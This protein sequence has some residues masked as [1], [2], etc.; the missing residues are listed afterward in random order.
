MKRLSLLLLVTFYTI[1]FAQIP[2]RLAYQGV[3]TDTLGN[4]KPDGI[5]TFT[6]RLY[7]TETGSTAEWTEIKDIEVNQGLFNTY[8]GDVTPFNNTINFNKPYYLGIKPGSEAELLPRIPLSA[9][10]YSFNSIKADT[11][12]ITLQI[13]DG[14]VTTSKITDG[15]VTTS[16]ILPG[17]VDVNVIADNSINES[18]VIDGSLRLIDIAAWSTAGNIGGATVPANGCVYF[19]FGDVE[20]ALADDLIVVR[21][22]I[23]VPRGTALNAHRENTVIGGVCNFTGTPVVLSNPFVLTIYGIR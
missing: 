14:L 8:L 11:A 22:S 19:N 18:K 20:G 5:Y 13:P 10:A 9:V 1:S 2:E 3:Y 21:A 16:K 23:T 12:E 17:A 7:E 6:F 15:A 4:P